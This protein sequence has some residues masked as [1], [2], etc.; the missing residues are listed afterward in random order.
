MQSDGWTLMHEDL[1]VA[2]IGF[3]EL[4]RITCLV[5]VKEAGHLPIG[6][7]ADDCVRCLGGLGRWWSLRSIPSSR[8]G[9]SSALDSLGVKTVGML[10][11]GSL[12]L[13]LSDSYW[14]RPASSDLAWGDVSPYDNGFS[15]DVGDALLCRESGENPD[16]RSPDP[17]TDGSLIKRWVS[18][19]EPVLHKGGSLNNQEPFDEV[20]ASWIMDR[21]RIGHV[22]YELRWIGGRPFSSCAAFTD[23][24]TELVPT[25]CVLES[26]GRRNDETLYEFTTRAITECGIENPSEFFDRMIAL[27][28][29]ISNEDRHLGNFGLLRDFET[30]EIRGFAPLYDNGMSMGCRETT[31]DIEQGYDLLCRPFKVTHGEQIRLVRD[32]D[33]FRPERLDGLEDFVS[34]LFAGSR[35]I[36]DSRRGEA[37][38]SY[39]RR[40]IDALC[41][42]SECPSIGDD[43]RLDLEVADR[44]APPHHRFR[45][46]GRCTRGPRAVRSSGLSH[47]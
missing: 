14:V 12:G 7:T 30:L 2:E 6:V 21:L 43:V 17:S 34:E 19:E 36:I 38:A 39:L 35:G 15:G 5:E 31:L 33:W 3:D 41:R 22:R 23:G 16:L 37:I 45:E 27:D 20:I 25:R 46:S 28:Y 44:F 24:R 8:P 1:E 47:P 13:S 4:G 11:L 18:E 32:L 42:Y 29:L 10:K 40:R 26:G 9:L